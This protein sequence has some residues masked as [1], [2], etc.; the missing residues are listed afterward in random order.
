VC[1]G[2]DHLHCLIAEALIARMVEE[3]HADDSD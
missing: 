2:L 1:D 3:D